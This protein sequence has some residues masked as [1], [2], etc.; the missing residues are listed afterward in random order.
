MVSVLRFLVFSFPLVIGGRKLAESAG[1][2]PLLGIVSGLVTAS[3]LASIAT[4]LLVRR[5]LRRARA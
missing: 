3:M 2:S 1:Y 4:G 5:S